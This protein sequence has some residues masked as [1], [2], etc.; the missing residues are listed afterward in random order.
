ARGRACIQITVDVFSLIAGIAARPM[1]ANGMRFAGLAHATRRTQCGER[2]P[3]G[4]KV[5]VP[6]K[7]SSLCSPG[8]AHGKPIRLE[9][10]RSARG[11]P[12]YIGSGK[13]QHHG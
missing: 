10:I 7:S 2:T 1:S 5:P 3:R 6:P 11:Y 4:T 13:H 8:W 12:D 9:D